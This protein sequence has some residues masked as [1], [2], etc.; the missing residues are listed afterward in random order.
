MKPLVFV[1]STLMLAI[2]LMACSNES[3][4]EAAA[5]TEPTKIEPT[6]TELA[7]AGAD[8]TSTPAVK[9][10]R[11][12]PAKAAAPDAVKQ[13]APQ[14][15]SIPEGTAIV[16]FLKDPISTATAKAGDTFAGSIA[17]PVVVNGETIIARGA[18]VKGR[19][20][21]AEGSG[22]VKGTASMRLAL[23]SIVAGAKTYPITTRPFVAEAE[24][25]KKRDAGIIGGAGG[26]GAAIGA[27]AGGGKGAVKG[28]IIGGAAGTG[29]V[30]ATKGKEVEFD[31][32]TKINFALEKPA[33][34]PKVR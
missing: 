20:I 17:D 8:A 5:T 2:T 6:K 11:P 29:A 16:V 15:V 10:E 26:V 1:L 9:S 7:K 34:V 3:G 31:T 12:A 30:L 23:T 28:A 4:Q 25:T 13:T 33:E 22:R 32:E 18:E 27:I 21:D 14:L 24:N 19:V